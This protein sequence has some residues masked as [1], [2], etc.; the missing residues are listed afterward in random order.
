MQYSKSGAVDPMP[1]ERHYPL[2]TTNPKQSLGIYVCVCGALCSA[3]H[4]GSH[5]LEHFPTTFSPLPFQPQYCPAT[6]QPN[7]RSFPSNRVVGSTVVSRRSKNSRLMCGRKNGTTHI[8]C[9][10]NVVTCA[11]R[12]YNLTDLQRRSSKTSR[13]VLP[14]HLTTFFRNLAQRSSFVPPRPRGLVG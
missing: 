5:R 13:N 9:I 14:E 6:T 11:R 12:W 2:S 10:G 8:W 3:S 1:R 4:A 7:L